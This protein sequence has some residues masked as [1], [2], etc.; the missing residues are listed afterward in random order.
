[1]IRRRMLGKYLVGC[2]L[3]ALGAY[4]FVHSGLGTDP[5]DTF[6]LGVLKHLPLTVGLVQLGVAVI[7][8]AAVALWTRR[9]PLLAPLFTFF[10]CGSM[11]DLLLAVDVLHGAGVSAVV[12]LAAGTLLCAYGSAFIIMSGFGIRAVDLLAIT[13]VQMWRWPFWLGKLLV[14]LTL[15]GTGY[16]LGG[17]AGVGTVVFLVGVGLLVQPLVRTNEALFGIVNLGLPR[18][19]EPLPGT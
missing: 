16:L 1:M 8:L 3:F 12:V 9:R 13:T 17:P 5:L 14:E 15:L 7:C 19:G 18:T 6:A 2:V 11:I 4:L 10:F